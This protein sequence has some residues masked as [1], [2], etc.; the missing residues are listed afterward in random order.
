MAGKSSNTAATKRPTVKAGPALAGP[1]AAVKLDNQPAAPMN[2]ATSLDAGTS[3]QDAQPIVIW[4]GKGVADYIEALK[5]R[6]EGV[7]LLQDL[8]EPLLR[9]VGQF[10]GVEN[11]GELPADQVIPLIEAKV[12]IEQQGSGDGAVTSDPA[13]G[14]GDSGLLQ[15]PPDE[16]VGNGPLNQALEA[17]GHRPVQ[18][19]FIRSVSDRGFRR[20]GH[21]FTPEGHGIALDVLTE[22]QIKTLVEDPN[23]RVELSTFSDEAE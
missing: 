12:G 1:A 16:Q 5:A 4:N 3:G 11:A 13:A 2:G 7:I 6:A 21:R 10:V 20:C 19:L 8:A 18:A 23:L 22:D 14:T 17:L 15:L 9:H